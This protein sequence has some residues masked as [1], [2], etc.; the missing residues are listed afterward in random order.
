MGS[1]HNLL[2]LS[3]SIAIAFRLTKLYE[4]GE[5][6]PNR[7]KIPVKPCEKYGPIE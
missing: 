1:G 2:S 6:G 7:V 4:Q 3:I 5:T